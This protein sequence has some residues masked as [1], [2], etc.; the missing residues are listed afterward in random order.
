MENG[1][2]MTLAD[3]DNSLAF[4]IPIKVITKIKRHSAIVVAGIGDVT[5]TR[6]ART[7]YSPFKILSSP[8]VSH[9]LTGLV[10][11]EWLSQCGRKQSQTYQ[12]QRHQRMHSKTLWEISWRRLHRG[13]ARCIH[14]MPRH[15]K[16]GG[17]DQPSEGWT[18]RYLQVTDL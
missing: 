14:T 18:L 9:T 17:L 6:P 7:L 5:Y 10:Q 4:S 15:P 1:L 16:F 3:G 11:I 13:H 8:T 12:F 2:V